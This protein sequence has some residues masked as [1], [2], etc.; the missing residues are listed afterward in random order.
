MQVSL[1]HAHT[2][3]HTHAH[4]HTHTHA[5]IQAHMRTICSLMFFIYYAH[6]TSKSC[7]NE[8]FLPKKDFDRGNAVRLSL[9]AA[10]LD[11]K[12]HCVRDLPAKL[13]ALFAQ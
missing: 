2:H 11:Y 3:E 1:G 5:H 8:Q 12:S 10:K 6:A 7:L 13:V 4:A 9:A